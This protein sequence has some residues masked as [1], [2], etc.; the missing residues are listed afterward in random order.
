MI[1]LDAICSPK[2]S[3]DGGIHGKFIDGTPI[4]V[5]KGSLCREHVQKFHSAII[6]A[7][8]DKGVMVGKSVP[9]TVYEKIAELKQE[10]IDIIVLRTQEIIN[11][12]FSKIREA[13]IEM[14]WQKNITDYV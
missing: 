11:G 5:K 7:K 6:T 2:M 13:G 1:H 12:D 14:R 9:R 10:G 3:A 8:K 4:E